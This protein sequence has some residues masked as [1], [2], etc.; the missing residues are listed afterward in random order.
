MHYELENICTSRHS[1][2]ENPSNGHAMNTSDVLYV[3]MI[4]RTEQGL[5]CS[6]TVVNT[7]NL[8]C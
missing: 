4:I 2:L 5:I 1:L 6:H 3:M 7:T 8:L